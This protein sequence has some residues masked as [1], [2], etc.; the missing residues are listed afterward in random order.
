MCL[1]WKRH[2]EKESKVAGWG[3]R[4]RE[5]DG[6]ERERGRERDVWL[7]RNSLSFLISLK[8]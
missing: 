8:E 4:E 7:L 6:E 2:V 3:E 5:K 1:W